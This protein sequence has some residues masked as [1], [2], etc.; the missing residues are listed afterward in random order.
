MRASLRLG[1]SVLA[2]MLPSLVL[3]RLTSPPPTMVEGL[4]LPR[5]LGPWTTSAETRLPD[6]VLAQ[7]EPDAYLMRRYSASGRAPIWVYLALYA[8]RAGYGK[9]A[10]DPEVC[11]PAQG[12]EV[13]G[14]TTA[15]IPVAGGRTFRARLLHVHNRGL[16]E[17]VVYWFQPARRW[18][19]PTAIEELLRVLDA[20]TGRPQYAFVRLSAPS[21]TDAPVVD[22]LIEFAAEVAPLIRAGLG[23]I[24][25]P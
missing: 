8:G 1:A 17:S 4:S 19:A 2:L 3:A 7:I 16:R 9:G 14:S 20:V 5:E 13:L 12:W 18:S 11:Y 10:H 21:R 6:D 24:G 25:G 22:D 15:E 23:G